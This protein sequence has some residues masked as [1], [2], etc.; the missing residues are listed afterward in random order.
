MSF[1]LVFQEEFQVVSGGS[2]GF[3]GHQGVQ[4]YSGEFERFSGSIRV[5]RGFGGFRG[6][7][8][9]FPRLSGRFRSFHGNFRVVQDGLGDF[10]G[11]SGGSRRI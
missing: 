10:N 9:I 4:G 8:E 5:S 6:F 1:F 11:A 3:R 2:K 7:Q